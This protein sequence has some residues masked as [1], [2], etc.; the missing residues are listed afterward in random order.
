MA[1]CVLI[2]P[3][4]KRLAFPVFRLAFILQERWDGLTHA[5]H[6][7]GYRLVE[8]LEMYDNPHMDSYLSDE[9]DGEL[10]AGLGSIHAFG[11]MGLADDFDSDDKALLGAGKRKV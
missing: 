8:A 5:K 9:Q 2:S 4:P 11:G 10:G 1:F 7:V 3:V 6:A